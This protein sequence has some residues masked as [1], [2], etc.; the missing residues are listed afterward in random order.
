MQTQ[1]LEVCRHSVVDYCAILFFGTTMAALRVGRI[2]FP[3]TQKCNKEHNAHLNAQRGG[4]Q[5]NKQLH[6]LL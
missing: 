1:N 5:D 4:V 6:I 3:S 2:L